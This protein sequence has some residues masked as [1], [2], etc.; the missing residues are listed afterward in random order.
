LTHQRNA[1]AEQ[2]A[3]TRRTF[4]P[5]DPGSDRNGPQN[6][7]TADALQELVNVIWTIEGRLSAL[8]GKGTARRL[9]AMTLP[10]RK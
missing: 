1:H 6:P 10:N 2:P 4:D 5:G 8:E 3:K 9:D 7:E